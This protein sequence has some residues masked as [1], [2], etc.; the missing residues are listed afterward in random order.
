MAVVGFVRKPNEMNLH[1]TKVTIFASTA[2]V[3]PLEAT[4]QH[5]KHLAIN[6][7]SV[8]GAVSFY[9]H[10]EQLH[11]DTDAWVSSEDVDLLD[12]RAVRRT[13]S[14][15]AVTSWAS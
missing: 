11:I 7:L 12:V 14:A 3:F 15:A 8:T 6:Q 13:R 5:Q 2:D 1:R 4:F 9:E 10:V